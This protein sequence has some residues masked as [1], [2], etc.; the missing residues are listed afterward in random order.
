[1]PRVIPSQHNPTILGQLKPATKFF[2]I[3]LA[4]LCWLGHPAYAAPSLTE[5]EVT[6]LGATLPL[7]QVWADLQTAQVLYLG[8]THDKPADHQAQ[9]FILENLLAGPKPLTLAMEMFQRPYQGAIDRYFK[10]ELTEAEFLAQTEY[11]TRWGFPWELYAPIVIL[12]KTQNIP[13][14]AL[15]TPSEVTRQVARKGLESLTPQ[16]RQFIP[17]Q[18]DI[19]L[20]PEGYRQQIQQIYTEMHRGKGNSTGGDRFFQAQVLWDETMAD[21]ITQAARLNPQTLIIVLVGQGH[22]LQDYGIP[23]RVAR[24]L[25]AIQ[26]RVILLNPENSTMAADYHWITIAPAADKSPPTPK[27]APPPPK[28]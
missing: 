1:M 16:Q 6:R 24:R 26:Q 3:L 23:A 20:G 28:T 12:A 10:G 19:F 8:E 25:P 5:P 11:K 18:N 7:P 27:S 2:P 21:R 4:L 22:L 14:I 17:E 9:K 15:N 13:L